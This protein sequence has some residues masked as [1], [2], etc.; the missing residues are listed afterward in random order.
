MG[1]QE[2]EPYKS[3]NLQ[4]VNF[5]ETPKPQGKSGGLRILNDKP[6]DKDKKLVAIII[7]FSNCSSYDDLFTT[8]EQKSLE[9][10][11]V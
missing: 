10:T 8:V 3:N 1:Q 6:E 7:S 9:G 5:Q 11:K 2:Y 4:N